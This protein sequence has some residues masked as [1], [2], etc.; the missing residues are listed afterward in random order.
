MRPITASAALLSCVFLVATSLPLSADTLPDRR[1][2]NVSGRGE[3]TATPD[4]ARISMQVET[5]KLDL[6]AAQDQVSRIVRDYL[7][8]V[9]ALGIADADIST[10]GLSIQ[11]QYDYS[12]KGGRKFLGYQLTRGIEI[13]VRDLDKIGDVLLKAT[14]AGINNVSDPQLESSKAE[15]LTR[16]ALAK[17]AEDARAKAKVLADALGVKLGAVHT[18]NANAEFV[19]APMAQKSRVLMMSAA[20]AAP[21]SGN[22]ALGFSAGQIRYNASVNADFDLVAP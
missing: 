15:A 6:R 14:T 12:A 19:P 3:V 7:A 20:D 4:R 17:A 22:E 18:L 5:T 10:A 8:Q 2:V 1:S 11:P 13:V 16:E 9:K 21:E